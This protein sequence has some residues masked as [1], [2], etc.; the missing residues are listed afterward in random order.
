MATIKEP[1]TDEELKQQYTEEY[2]APN[3]LMDL[4]GRIYHFLELKRLEAWHSF[5]DSVFPD[6]FPFSNLQGLLQT[7]LDRIY[8]AMA[9]RNYV[10]GCDIGGK[11]SQGF[12]DMY[13]DTKKAIDNEVNKMRN[14]IETEVVDPVKTKADQ[15]AKD[16]KTAQNKLKDMGISIDGFEADVNTMKN[17]ISSFDGSIKSFNNKLS[18][19][20]GKLKTLESTANNLKTQLSDA[21]ARL[22]Q[23][24]SLI[25][26]LTSRVEKLEGKQKEGLSLLNILG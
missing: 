10:K 11:I 12:Y 17:N 26:N 21:E 18:S 4:F 2:Q 19:F 23:Y 14:Y 20:D 13:D 3:A 9:Y 22:N 16:L 1:Y 24:K 6:Y 5:V 15:I 8:E 7:V 25:D